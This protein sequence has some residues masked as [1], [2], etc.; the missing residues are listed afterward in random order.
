[1]LGSKGGPKVVVVGVLCKN[2]NKCCLECK[3]GGGHWEVVK[4]AVGGKVWQR[5]V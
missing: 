4:G 2:G 3:V 5:G 1:M